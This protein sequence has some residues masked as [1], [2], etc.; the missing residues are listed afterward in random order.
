MAKLT[1]QLEA[2]LAD[3]RRQAESQREKN[4]A[5]VQKFCS[6]LITLHWNETIQDVSKKM[7]NL[8]QPYY[9]A[10][11]YSL[12]IGRKYFCLSALVLGASAFSKA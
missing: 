6:F 7:V 2:A 11:V 5:K 4:I 3:A 8:I 10:F 1:Y 12:V 9:C